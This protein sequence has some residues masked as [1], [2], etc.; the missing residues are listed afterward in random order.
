MNSNSIVFFSSSKN[1]IFRVRVWQKR[2]SSSEFEL[3]FEFAALIAT[4]LTSYFMRLASN[5]VVHGRCLE[6]CKFHRFIM[7]FAQKHSGCANTQATWIKIGSR[8]G[9]L[10]VRIYD[11]L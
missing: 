5:E 9:S 11:I 6:A 2:S 8:N 1:C 10:K 7:V 3:K 4:I